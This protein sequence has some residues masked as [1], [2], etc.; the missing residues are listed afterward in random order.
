MLFLMKEQASEG[1]LIGPKEAALRA[2]TELQMTVSAS[3]KH[4]HFPTTADFLVTSPRVQKQQTRFYKVQVTLFVALL[5]LHVFLF[6][7]T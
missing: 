2:K 3:I 6:L 1:V 4:L 5:D 7:L